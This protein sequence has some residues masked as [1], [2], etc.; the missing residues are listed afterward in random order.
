LD[1]FIKESHLWNYYTEEKGVK[2]FIRTMNNG[3][4]FVE[5]IS[6]VKA[7]P[8]QLMAIIIDTEKKTRWDSM[9]QYGRM[10]CELDSQTAI[11]YEH[12]QPVVGFSARDFSMVLR[13]EKLQDGSLLCVRCSV[14]HPGVPPVPASVRGEHFGAF[15]LMPLKNGTETLIKY[16][17][18]NDLKIMMPNYLLRSTALK[19]L[20]FIPTLGGILEKMSPEELQQLN[21]TKFT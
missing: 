1:Y 17:E 19:W 10:V 20:D 11:H 2:K 21:T 13:W 16:L 3:T 4:L 5:G 6:K 18:G 7:T 15:H 12:Y 8:A 9:L 14:V